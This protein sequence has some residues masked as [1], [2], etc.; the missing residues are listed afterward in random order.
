MIDRF[1]KYVSPEPNSGCWLWTGPERTN[2]YG[3]FSIGGKNFYAH[4]WS[5]QYHVGEIPQG[6]NVCHHCDTPACVNP[7]HL[8]IG[9]QKDNLQ[10]ASKKGRT[11]FQRYPELC[12]RG[13]DS[14]HAKL[15]DDDIRRIRRLV[16]GGTRQAALARE[17][18]VSRSAIYGIVSRKR[19]KHIETV[20]VV[21]TEWQ[22]IDTAPRD[23]TIVLLSDG[24]NRW[25]SEIEDDPELKEIAKW[26][27][28][29][30]TA[31]HWMPL[32]ELPK[33]A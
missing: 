8:W 14:P 13:I 25:M 30:K 4:R 6:L 20:K 1:M 19:W 23:G 10:D 3:S 31:T 7:K 21:M 17:Y 11:A 2:G 27:G 22:T 29:D 9:T 33:V 12:K 15:V 5:Y 28:W 32:P 24:K 26:C 16:A 18:G